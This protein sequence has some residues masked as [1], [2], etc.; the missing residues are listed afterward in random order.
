[1]HELHYDK[2]RDRL[3]KALSKVKIGDP[4]SE[5]TEMGPMARYDLVTGLHA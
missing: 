5:D 1:M 3:V 4:L 2:F